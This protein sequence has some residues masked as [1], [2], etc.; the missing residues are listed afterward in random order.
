MADGQANRLVFEFSGHNKRWAKPQP[1]CPL[2]AYV[3]GGFVV[4][5][6]SGRPSGSFTH[7][8]AGP[9]P[10]RERKGDGERPSVF[11]SVSRV[12]KIYQCIAKMFGRILS[13]N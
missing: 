7:L 10:V 4:L 3:F 13:R 9:P 12:C 2:F 5:C 8:T 1:C 6:E 11:V